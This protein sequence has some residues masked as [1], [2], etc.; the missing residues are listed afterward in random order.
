MFKKEHYRQNH[1]RVLESLEKIVGVNYA[2]DRIEER[3]YYSSDPS[4]Q[5]PCTPEFV[6]MPGTVEEIQEILRLANREKIPVTPRVGGLTLSGLSIPYGEGIL[7]DLKR[8]DKIIE[9]NKDSMYAVVECGVTIGQLKTYLEENYPDLWFSMPHAPQA[10][11]VVSNALI[12]G[13]GQV[14]LGYGVSSDMVNGLE[15]VLPSG[16]VLRTGSCA[17]GRSWL[18]K[19]CLPDFLGLFLG[20]FGATGII[21]KAS[22]QLWPKPIFRD[23]LFFKIY[24]VDDIVPLLSKL[25]KSEVCEDICLFS[26]TG[27]SG[28]ERFHLLDKPENVAEITMDLIFSGGTQKEMELKKR[29]VR[30]IS[31]DLFSKGVEMEEYTRPPHIK[32]GVLIVPRIFPFMD[33]LQGGG[34]EYLGCYIPL[35]ITRSAYK[36][37][38]EIARKHGLQYL[39]FVR[40]L[41]TGHVVCVLYIFPFDKKDSNQV[42]R[43]L[44]VLEEI[45]DACIKLGGV[46]WKPSPSAQR[47]ILKYADVE[48]LNFMKKIKELLDPNGI[49]APGQWML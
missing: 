37:G 42:K 19:Y 48:Y 11:G 6:A 40:P 3:Y 1:S 33:L 30:G 39:H 32:T 14:S 7:L 24:D 10:V 31:S 47:I 13:A 2:T 43:L 20:W 18:T 25:T 16:D 17:L 28:R 36:K 8:M 49:M 29:V 35:E 41:R 5:E 9:V 46:V 27:T 38:V 15:V 44:K 23:A 45:S 12:F 34:T 4:A 26:W 21:T 22:I